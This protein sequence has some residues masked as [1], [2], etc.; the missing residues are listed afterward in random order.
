MALRNGDPARLTLRAI[1]IFVNVV[2]AGSLG[3]AVDRVQASPSSISQHVSNLETALGARLLDRTA[4]PLALTPAG[5]MF[6]ERARII[7]DQAAGA[8]S[9]LA[10][11][12]HAEWPSLGIAVVEDFDVDIAPG[13]VTGLAALLPRCRIACRTGLSHANFAALTD[14][15]V[16][17]AIA[18]E[19]ERLPDG[20]E[21]HPLMRDP[22][23]LVTARGLV[24]GAADPLDVLQ[25]APM[26]A[27]SAAQLMHRQ[28]GAQFRRL[29]FEPKVRFE[30]D[31]SEAIMAMVAE[32]RGWTVTTPLGFLRA[33]RLHGA[34]EMRPLPFRGFS[35]NL[36]LYARRDLLGRLPTRAAAILRA[37]IAERA[38]AVACEAAPWLGEQ[39][40]VLGPDGGD[41]SAA[42]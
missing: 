4:R 41:A 42:A 3:G 11:L 20:I 5:R 2:E 8:R 34:I 37:L 35:R 23:V 39:I 32:T 33:V 36:S 21:R 31:S 18:A 7:L 38:V 29:R 9:E 30:F 16:D 19:T 28:I 24:D 40:R 6:L 14:R 1:E 12:G 22:Y 17:M 10:E 13:L 25:H 27:Y 15:S 26:V